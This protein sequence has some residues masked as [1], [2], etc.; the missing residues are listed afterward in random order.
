LKVKN[1]LKISD[2]LNEQLKQRKFHKHSWKNKDFS[3]KYKLELNDQLK[4][5]RYYLEENS[6]YEVKCK[7]TSDYLDK[8]KN[9]MI[10]YQLG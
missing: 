6:C 1:I 8:I 2:E 10:K 4:L 5:N 3:G 7:Y 9:S